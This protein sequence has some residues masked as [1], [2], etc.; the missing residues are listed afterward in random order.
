M[1]F[2]QFDMGQSHVCGLEDTTG[3]P[4]CWGFNEYNC[5]ANYTGTWVLGTTAP[6][7]YKTPLAFNGSTIEPLK[8]IRAGYA[9]TTVVT[10]SG[11]TGYSIGYSSD[12][13]LGMSLLYTL[14]C[15]IYRV[16]Q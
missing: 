5:M 6:V 10:S 14:D 16:C 11:N 8:F 2:S 4:Y 12:G 7:K 15:S 9:M 1:A 3:K 13:Q